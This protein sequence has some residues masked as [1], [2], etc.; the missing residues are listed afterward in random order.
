MNGKKQIQKAY[1]SI[2][3]NDF[4]QA[5]RSFEQAIALEPDNA[6]YHYKLSITYARSGK[7]MHALD[8]AERACTLEP[9][10][11]AYRFHH[12][13]LQALNLVSQAEKLAEAGGKR[14]LQL[15]ERL[16]RDAVRKD[17]L[18]LEAYLLLSAVYVELGDDRLAARAV[19]EVLKLNPQHDAALEHIK[20]NQQ[21]F[22]P[23]FDHT[24]KGANNHDICD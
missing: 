7:L 21:R 4:E 8:Y 15:A 16:L 17:A 14:R 1:E 11:D 22:A 13:H 12:Q 24:D 20:R 18:C 23:F 2:L 9:A 10:H 3:D 5:I 6:E 19:Q